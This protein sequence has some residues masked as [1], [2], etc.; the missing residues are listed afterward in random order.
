MHGLDLIDLMLEFLSLKFK[1]ISLNLNLEQIGKL[2][3][4]ND[5]ESSSFF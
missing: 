1:R 4:Y 2:L 5:G 3:R